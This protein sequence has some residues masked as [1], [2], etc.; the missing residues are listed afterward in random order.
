MCDGFCVFASHSSP[1]FHDHELGPPVLASVNVTS[2][3]AVPDNT[4][5]L[6]SETGATGFGIPSDVT[7]M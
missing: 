6:K 7:V 5:A 2:S 4:S 3:G 1:K